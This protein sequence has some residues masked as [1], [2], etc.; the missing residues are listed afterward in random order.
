M[1]KKYRVFI[2]GQEGTTGL[3]LRERL[4]PREDIE[5]ILIDEDKRRDVSER[6]RL[7]NSADA[8]FLCLP[9]DAAKESVS[10]VENEDVI[11]IDASTAHR[12]SDGWAYGFPELSKAH[13]EKIASSKRIA[14]PGCHATGFSALVYP[15]VK[16]G[17]IA[18]DYPL[19]CHSI[20]G[21]SG[22]GKKM[23]AEYEDEARSPLLKSPRQYGLTL[24]HKHLP[25]MKHVTGISQKPLF[26]PIVCDFFSGMAVSVPLHVSLMQKKPSLAEMLDVFSGRY[27]GH[28]LISVHEGNGGGFIAANEIEGTCRMKIYVCGNA[29]QMT[30]ISVLDNL[31]KGASGAAVQC[32]NIALGIDEYKSLI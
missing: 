24:A 23:I 32:M 26:N 8:V 17:Y 11:I 19:V 16:L 22:G 27:A 5:L 28:G 25:E 6:K 13:R 12:T 20:T 2:D 7:I 4:Q 14:V 10:L 29:E 30:L 18:G 1:L 21:Y 31:G 9:D 15:L 3:K